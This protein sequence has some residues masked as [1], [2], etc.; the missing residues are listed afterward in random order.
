MV[1]LLGCSLAQAKVIKA[2]Y[3]FDTEPGVGNGSSIDFDPDDP[4]FTCFEFTVPKDE[5]E[6][7]SP[8]THHSSYAIKTTRLANRSCSWK[9]SLSPRIR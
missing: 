3:F 4:E 1:S 8:G 9:A 7:L 5:M 6:L 2:E